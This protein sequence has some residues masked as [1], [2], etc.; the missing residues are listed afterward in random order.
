MNGNSQ[1]GQ[2]AAGV[3]IQNNFSQALDK[4]AKN[5]EVLVLDFQQ[6]MEPSANQY[7]QFATPAGPVGNMGIGQQKAFNG[8]SFFQSR[9]STMN[10]RV[11]NRAAARSSVVMFAGPTVTGDASDIT[12]KEDHMDEEMAKLSNKLGIDDLEGEI[13]GK[14][15]IM[16]VD[17]NVPLKDGEVTDP[18][19]ISSTI[20]SIKY[21]L[22]QGAKSI[23]LMSHMGRPDGTKQDK[24][25]LKQVVSTLEKE[26]GKEVTFVPDCQGDEVAKVCEEAKDGEI[27]LL[28]NLRFYAAEEGKGV[29]DGEKF[30]A[31]EEEIA[32]FRKQLTALG[33][34]YVNDAFGTAHRAHSS[35]VG[36]DAEKKAAGFLMKKEL[37]YF[38]KVLENP[39]RPLTV[40]MGGAKVKDKIQLIYNMLDIVDEMIIGGGMAYTFDKVLNKTEIGSSLYDEEGAKIVEDIMKKAEEKNVKIHLPTDYVCADKFAADAETKVRTQ[41]EGIEEGWMGLDIGPKTIESNAEVIKRSNTVFWNGPQGVFEMEPFAK[42]SLS[43]LDNIIEATARGATSVAGGGDTVAL[44]Q[45]VEGSS[46]KLS[47]VSTGGGASLELVEGK[48]LPG[49]VALSDKK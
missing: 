39:V 43:M 42:G 41:E 21:L 32:D 8:P 19:R 14:K 17:F 47:H 5:A 2:K 24:F 35:M 48:E 30:K 4:L 22:E 6:L 10:K 15:I 3:K 13:K 29:K 23:V 45:G 34:I 37:D 20:P 25:S 36:V 31:T 26:L 16:R 9:L 28:D 40:V 18:K 7:M 12:M 46:E 49:V 27:I 44:L 11:T 38:G 1:I 33:D